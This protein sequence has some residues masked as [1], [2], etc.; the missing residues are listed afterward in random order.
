MRVPHQLTEPGR[1]CTTGLTNQSVFW[2][3]FLPGLV[4]SLGTL[5]CTF[6]YKPVG[7]VDLCDPHPHGVCIGAVAKLHLTAE[8]GL[9]Q[10]YL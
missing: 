1:I 7:G 3:I 5:E 10:E 2:Y 6:L 4:N 9:H 8:Q